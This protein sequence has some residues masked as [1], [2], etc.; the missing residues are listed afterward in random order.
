MSCLGVSS[1][2]LV[3]A[4]RFCTYRENTQHI[5][6]EGERERSP[7]RHASLAVM[8]PERMQSRHMPFCQSLEGTWQCFPLSD[9]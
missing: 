2:P 4:S 6:R 5:Q 9:R 3:E 8:L 1:T 7:L